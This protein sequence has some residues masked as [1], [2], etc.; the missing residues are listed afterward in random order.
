[1]V[2]RLDV[3][4]CQHAQG[5]V[6]CALQDSLLHDLNILKYIQY[7][8]LALKNVYKSTFKIGGGLVLC[9]AFAFRTTKDM[10]NYSDGHNYSCKN[11][12]TDHVLAK[13]DT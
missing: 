13:T 4:K 1:M 5:H 9:L 10:E 6:V 8:I 3:K 12:K 2:Y 11:I 7:S